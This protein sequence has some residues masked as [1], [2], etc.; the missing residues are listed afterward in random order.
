MSGRFGGKRLTDLRRHLNNS[1]KKKC[2]TKSEIRR[3]AR[4]GGVMR[5]NGMVYDEIQDV[6]RSFLEGVICDAIVY[7]EFRRC[8]TVNA[9]DVV[10]ALKRRG[11]T[12]YGFEK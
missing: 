12:L 3:L 10:S 6:L 2:P 1:N 7:T 8:K 9:V 11:R 5:I 4:R